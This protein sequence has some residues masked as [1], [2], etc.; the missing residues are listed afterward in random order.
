MFKDDNEQSGVGEVPKTGFEAVKAQSKSGL[1]ASFRNQMAE[2]G[3]NLPPST[4]KKG[5]NLKLDGSSNYV[6]V[7]GDKLKRIELTEAEK[8]K[9]ENELQKTKEKLGIDGETGLIND[10]KGDK[11]VFTI[12][13]DKETFNAK[14]TLKQHNLHQKIDLEQILKENQQAVAARAE[15]LAMKNAETKLGLLDKVKNFFGFGKAK[16]DQTFGEILKSKYPE[17]AKRFFGEIAERTRL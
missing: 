8:T 3:I 17:D 9:V 12:K 10:N 1:L 11:A 6:T 15:K 5:D 13:Y 7:N 16:P 14:P 4:G 2:N